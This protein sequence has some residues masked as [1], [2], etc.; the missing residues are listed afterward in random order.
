[1]LQVDAARSPVD[2][3]STTVTDAGSD[4]YRWLAWRLRYGKA[5][6]GGFGGGGQLA[7]GIECVRW[8][9]PCGERLREPSP[10]ADYRRPVRQREVPRDS[11]TQLGDGPVQISGGQAGNPEG[12][13][14]RSEAGDAQTRHH[15]Q[16]GV[17]KEQII[18]AAG[19]V[20][21]AEQVSGLHDAVH[22]HQPAARSGQLEQIAAAHRGQRARCGAM[23]AGLGQCHGQ[24]RAHRVV[25]HAK[26]GGV[27]DPAQRRQHFAQA[28]LIPADSQQ[29]R[30][31]PRRRLRRTHCLAAPRAGL[32]Q[33]FSP[34]KVAAADGEHDIH[35]GEHESHPAMI[36]AR[37]FLPQLLQLALRVGIAVG[38][39]VSGAPEQADQQIAS[40]SGTEALADEFGCQ[41]PAQPALPRPQQAVMRETESFRSGN[42]I[43][44]SAGFAKHSKDHRGS[45]TSVVRLPGEPDAQA[46][47]ERGVRIGHRQGPA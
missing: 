28:T 25:Y 42:R 17:G 21:V 2:A 10:R 23:V 38:E 18:G 7:T 39:Q 33:S 29:V 22:R 47:R 31:V 11:G 41:L 19:G 32:S 24:H 30:C 34:L 15:R 27:D 20:S 1:M 40:T 4:R 26:Y 37:Q 8:P 43:P 13:V 14:D 5:N 6:R 46:Q 16:V 12:M 35:R 44:R 9:G 3:S 36:F 45:A